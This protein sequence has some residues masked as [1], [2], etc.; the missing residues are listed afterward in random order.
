MAV[1][2][3]RA[4]GRW[5]AALA[6]VA[7][8][9]PALAALIHGAARTAWDAGEIAALRAAWLRVLANDPRRGGGIGPQR[10]VEVT[11]AACRNAGFD[12]R[13]AVDALSA[14]QPPGPRFRTCL[15]SF[16]G[17]S[18]SATRLLKGLGT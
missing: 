14:P 7:H 8:A 12:P 10:L 3:R 9:A 16:Q 5:L 17:R 18:R 4:L 11:Q 1:W 13:V 6:L 2:H 15:R